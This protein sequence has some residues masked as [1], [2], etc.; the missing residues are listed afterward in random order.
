M[1]LTDAKIRAA[2]PGPH[3]SWIADRDGLYLRVTPK[4]S[5]SFY[6]RRTVGGKRIQ[7]RLGR[8]PTLTLADA[9]KRVERF[10]PDAPPAPDTFAHVL[11]EYERRRIRAT[12]KR[13]EHFRPYKRFATERLGHLKPESITTAHLSRLVVEY[14]DKRGKRTADALRSHLRTAIAWANEQGWMPDVARGISSK[15]S[16]YTYVPRERVLTDDEIRALWN[17]DSAHT[18]LLRALLLTG[19]RIGELQPATHDEIDGDLLRIPAKRSKNGDPHWVFITP[20]LREQFVERRHLFTQ[21]TLTGTQSWLRRWCDREGIP[22]FTPHD[23]RRTFNT[24]LNGDL[25]IAPHV[26]EKCMNHRMQGVMGVYNRA[27]YRDERI[28]AYQ[29][30]G[31]AL[32]GIVKGGR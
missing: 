21:Q 26:V 10:N 13:P 19:L 28:A 9:R 16:G 31:K 14:G 15:T 18:P 11:D 30:W 12:Y 6:L 22:R 3:D 5:R 25:G 17:A 1:P 4:G 8:W 20:T 7:E 32:Q 2:K 23:L 27:E 24:R 29:A